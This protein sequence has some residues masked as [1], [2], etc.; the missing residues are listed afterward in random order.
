VAALAVK[1]GLIVRYEA[2]TM[3]GGETWLEGLERDAVRLA[4]PG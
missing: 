1:I 2:A 3:E 4:Q